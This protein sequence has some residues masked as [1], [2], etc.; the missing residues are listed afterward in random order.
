MLVIDL[1][2][3]KVKLNET[4]DE[5]LGS[6]TKTLLK[7]MYGKDVKVIANLNENDGPQ[8]TIRGK[9]KDVKAYA[10]AVSSKKDFLDSYLE[11]GNQHPQTVKKRQEL[12]ANVS[13]FESITGLKW[14]FKDED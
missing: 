14:P 4:W 13:N 2:N 3:A 5:M 10:K 1:E 9:Y 11:F 8:F 12:R 7:Y 6:W